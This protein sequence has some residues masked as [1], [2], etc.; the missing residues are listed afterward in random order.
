MDIDH[1]YE[2]DEGVYNGKRHNFSF[3][4]LDQEGMDQHLN[5][6]FFHDACDGGGGDDD[7]GISEEVDEVQALSFCHNQLVVLPYLLPRFENLRSLD[8]STNNLTHLD[9]SLLR[10][11]NLVS[12]VVK[13][14]LLDEQSLPKSFGAMQQL[15]ELNFSGNHFRAIP[16]QVME[17]EHL[18]FLYM[19]GN[20][21]SSV[22]SAIR[23]LQRLEVLHLGGNL[24]TEIAT[25]VGCLQNLESLIL[26]ENRLE[27][28]PASISHLKRLRF[29][30]LHR[31]A[32][33]T[34]PPEIVTLRCLQELTLRD[35]PL[36]VRFIRDM[37]YDP[38]SLLELAARC[39][40]QR[41][42]SIAQNDLPPN[43]IRYLSTAQRCVNPRCKGVYF[44]V[45]IQH[46]KFVD[47]CG[48]Y[49]IPLLQY[50]CTPK[51][52]I[53]PAVYNSDSDVS[54]DDSEIPE[55]KLKKVLL[56]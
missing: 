43:L 47:F 3:L 7:S 44:N 55:S 6:V 12:L 18:R 46:I 25:E 21:L 8:L 35:N 4:Q 19:G 30:A 27:S 16:S 36:V 49:R 9:D 13:N 54:E 33:T 32:L 42:I 15:V 48:K 17:L 41:N 28:L 5:N 23:Q 1:G 29:L 10:L 14:N 56:G 11:T 2:E 52:R 38:P 39:L 24:L 26:C 37:M 20:Q 45:C 34:L 53:Q 31:N 40:K 51:C 50:L 22:P